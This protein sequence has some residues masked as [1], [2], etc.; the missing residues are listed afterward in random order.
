MEKLQAVSH[1]GVID[2]SIHYEETAASHHIQLSPQTPSCVFQNEG[3][4]L[5]LAIHP[6]HDRIS[7]R[8]SGC[9]LRLRSRSVLFFSW[10]RWGLK[11]A[12]AETGDLY[13][14]AS[15]QTAL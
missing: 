15:Y 8:R 11:G 7:L 2:F 3:M 6:H 4:K 5:S 10:W 9:Y 1:H 14:S 12:A 13:E